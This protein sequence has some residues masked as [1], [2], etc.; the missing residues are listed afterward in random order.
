MTL[1]LCFF[2]LLMTF[3]TFEKTTYMRLIGAFE[4]HAEDSL[5]DELQIKNT[6]V[7]PVLTPA[8]AAEQGSRT[9][10]EEQHERTK[11][12]KDYE[13]VTDMDAYKDRR[14]SYLPCGELF[15]GRGN[16][17]TPEGKKRLRLIAAFAELVPC[18]IVI[19][20]RRPFGGD[21][22]DQ[23]LGLA[24]S[25]SVMEGIMAGGGL[26]EERF[27]ISLRGSAPQQSRQAEAVME[28]VLLNDKVMW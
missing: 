1:L 27:S 28:V 24:R 17:L 12:V 15:Y 16:R 2:V 26:G 13:L 23:A 21:S 9:P 4:V 20:E 11:Q 10:M 14:V 6:L 3:S 5:F 7:E 8:N 25:A 18:R 22:R 19:G